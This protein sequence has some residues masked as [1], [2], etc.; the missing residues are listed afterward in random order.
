[1]RL[2]KALAFV[3]MLAGP[4]VAL[5]ADPV[6][7]IVDHN[8]DIKTLRAFNSSVLNR[9]KVTTRAQSRY[10]YEVGWG[11]TTADTEKARWT[12]DFRII[13]EMPLFSKKEAMEMRLREFQLRRQIRREAASAVS[14]YRGLKRYIK[15]EEAIVEG[16]AAECRWMEQRVQVGLEPQKALMNCVLDLRERVKN[17]EV[18]REELQDA[19]EAVLSLVEPGD[20][21]QLKKILEAH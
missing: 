9:L 20:R 2:I 11:D 4:G 19:L 21:P 10:G 16:L 15:R 14:R 6:Q 1:M 13:A 8:P 7:F 18:K 12:Y 17:L 5:G 3:L